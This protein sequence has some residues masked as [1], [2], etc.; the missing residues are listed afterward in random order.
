M[1]FYWVSSTPKILTFTAFL[2]YFFGLC[3]VSSPNFFQKKKILRSQ[4]EVQLTKLHIFGPECQNMGDFAVVK[5][6]Q[7]IFEAKKGSK[8]KR[9]RLGEQDILT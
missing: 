2:G 3:G 6:P 9:G 1:G 4:H 8:F 7:G 5:A